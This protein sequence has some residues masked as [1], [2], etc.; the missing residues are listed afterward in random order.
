MKNW[1]KVSVCS[2]FTFPIL[3]I[4]NIFTSTIFL[5]KIT[6]FQKKKKYIVNKNWY[7]KDV[8]KKSISKINKL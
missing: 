2:V 7:K 5:P 8:Q 4:I 3:W 1:G 6:N